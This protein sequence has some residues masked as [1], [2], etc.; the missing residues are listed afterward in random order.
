MASTDPTGGER[1]V[2]LSLPSAQANFLRKELAGLKADLE[3]DLASHP[4]DPAA[5][6]WRASAAA[7]GRLLAGLEAGVIIPDAEVRCLVRGWTE[8]NDREEQYDRVIFEH[9]ALHALRS[10]LDG[11]RQ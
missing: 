11:G 2:P 10:Q 6:R 7:Y 4:D 9:E 5:E 8:A 1:A 3:A